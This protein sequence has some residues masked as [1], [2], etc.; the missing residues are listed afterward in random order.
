MHLH[1]LLAEVAHLGIALGTGHLVAALLLLVPG[2]ALV[3]L[4]THNQTKLV[5]KLSGSGF[6]S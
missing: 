1:G 6:I 5:V 3:A 2:L 4:S